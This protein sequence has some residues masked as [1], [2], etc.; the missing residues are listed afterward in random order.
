MNRK[1]KILMISPQFRPLVGGYE[2]AAE[3]LAIALTKKGHQVQIVTERRDR[4]WPK[5]EQIGQATLLRLWCIF[6]PGVH[7]FSSLFSLFLFLIT[8]GWRFD[9]WHVHQY[10]DYAGLAILIGKILRRPVIFKV[11]S[12]GSMGLKPVIAQTRLPRI[13]RFLH[14]RAAGVAAL[15]VQTQ[16][17][18]IDFGVPA[19]RVHIIGNGVDTDRFHPVDPNTRQ[20][21][22]NELGLAD[23]RYAIFVG[24]FC[25]AKNTMG[26]VQAWKLALQSLPESWDLIMLGEGSDWQK[27]FDYC[28]Q[29]QLQTRVHLVGQQHS[30]EKWLQIADINILSSW[31][32]GMSNALL[33]AMACGLPTVAT[34]VSGVAELIENEE[35]GIG[36]PIGDMPALG[37]AILKLALN[38]PQRKQAGENARRIIEGRYSLASNMTAYERLY[39]QL[40]R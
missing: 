20:Q 27:V 17:E 15:T 1:L 11:T 21:L 35:A 34:R 40:C 16:I 2:K 38:D 22:R 14:R 23:R 32:E 7:K 8:R 5:I 24:R 25:E 36:V 31:N 33:E 26:L 12:S 28:H 10:G 29:N 13:N 3:R 30:V 37:N 18:A 6:R 9:I 39:F 4:S 19:E